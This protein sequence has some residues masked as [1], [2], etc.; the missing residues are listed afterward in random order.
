VTEVTH[1]TR[2]VG[3]TDDEEVE[4]VPVLE[5][6]SA[7]LSNF[8]SGPPLVAAPEQ[9]ADA[10]PRDVAR[11]IVAHTVNLRA[12]RETGERYSTV[13]RRKETK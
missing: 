13:A 9:V 3:V 1:L 5:T 10:S 11:D 2:I 12:R 4:P 8:E 7:A 6:G